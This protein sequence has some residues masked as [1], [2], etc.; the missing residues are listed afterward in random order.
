MPSDEGPSP[1]VR[2]EIE[3]QLESLFAAISG[4]KRYLILHSPAAPGEASPA[5]KDL[6]DASKEISE[7]WTGPDA[8]EEIRSQREK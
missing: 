2:E 7:R 3:R 6:M 5:W 8:V 1:G 4:L